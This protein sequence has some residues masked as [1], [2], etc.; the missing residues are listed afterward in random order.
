MIRSER[1]FHVASSSNGSAWPAPQRWRCPSST[2]CSRSSGR[3][4]RV[5]RR[6]RGA[7][8]GVLSAAEARDAGRR[9]RA[10]HSDR[11]ERTRRSRGTRV[12]VHRSRARR[13]AR[14]LARRVHRRPRRYS[15]TPHEPEAVSRFVELRAGR[16][17]RRARRRSSRRRSLRSSGRTRFKA[18]SAI[19]PMAA[20]RTSSAGI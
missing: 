16:T 8:A 9:L 6:R 19:P 3:H 11:R 4:W 2:A 10:H 17:G 13:M 14:A 12:A 15:T 20:T 1:R 18:R 5:H 7:P